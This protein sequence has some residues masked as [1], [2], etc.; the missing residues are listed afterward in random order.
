MKRLLSAD[1]NQSPSRKRLS[2]SL[3]RPEVQ[4]RKPP[5][6]FGPPTSEEDVRSAAKGVIPLNTKCSNAWALGNLRSWMETQNSNSD[7]KV[8]EDL[9]SCPEAE[10]VC[11]WLC[12]FVHETRKE[13]GERYPP[14]TIRCLLSA[15]Q[16]EMQDN[17]L[18]YRLF[19]RSDLR[20][21][22]LRK[23]LDTVC[24]SLRKDGIGALQQHAAVISPADEDL[25]W[26]SGTLGMDNPWALTRA[27][28]VTVGLHFCLRGGQEHRD[29]KVD[30][31]RRVPSD[32]SY[33]KES[34]YEYVEHGSKNHQGKFAEI[35]SNK[36][37]RAF[38][39][40]GSGR[41]PVKILDLY[42]SKLPHN[43]YFYM[44]PLQAVPSD[45]HRPWYKTTPIGVN[46]LKN[47]L[48]KVS[49]LAGLR[50]RY[51][52]HSLRATAATRMFAA[53]VPEKVIAEFT[54]HKSPKALHQYERTSID[55]VQAA[56]LAIARNDPKDRKP[57]VTSVNT[58]EDKEN[59]KPEV[60]TEDRKPDLGTLEQSLVDGKPDL[61]AIQQSLPTFS[62][63]L[64]NCTINIKL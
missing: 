15:F 43:Y 2:L 51:T 58:K 35:D 45:P 14:A 57:L 41:C 21:Q 37:S 25:M 17:K 54:G 11:K 28:F 20:F 56:G 29:L 27:T 62:G 30:Q 22:D 60:D 18:S 55:Q 61:G 40:P 24:V 47:M 63:N 4:L 42:L 9:L 49:E 38:A 31:F 50:S 8:P 7:E 39:Q 64:T 6:R 13:N 59:R 36:V 1:E 19:D 16:R 52:N 32:G 26:E 23:T 5:Q 34:F 53:G 44:Q 10:V 3:R 48:P 33:S 12:R 46:P